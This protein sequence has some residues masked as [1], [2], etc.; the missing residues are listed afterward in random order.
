MTCQYLGETARTGHDRGAE[1]LNDLNTLI[2]NN[3]L[4]TH[5]IE[6]HAE[7]GDG[8]RGPSSSFTMK[9]QKSFVS[10]LERQSYEG[11]KIGLFKGQI[12][13]NKKG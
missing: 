8:E 7:D 1:H 11:Y 2:K 4:V 12:L 10:P 9:I 13:M 5:W 3:A 6:H